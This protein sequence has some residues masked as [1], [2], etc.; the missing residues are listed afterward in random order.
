M[1]LMQERE[2]RLGTS[3]IRR[4]AALMILLFI[5]LP[6]LILV[7]VHTKVGVNPLSA[8]EKLPSVRLTPVSGTWDGVDSIRESKAVALIFNAECPHCIMMLYRL[9][10]LNRRYADKIRFVGISLSP[11][12]TTRNLVLDCKLTFPVYIAQDDEIRKKFRISLVPAMIFLD[13]NLV[14]RHQIAGEVSEKVVEQ[15][16]RALIREKR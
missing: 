1:S 3:S 15:A 10:W 6:V 9:N 16:L 13:S 5:T 14:I 7:Y 8:G 4:V 2:T 11:A 12:D